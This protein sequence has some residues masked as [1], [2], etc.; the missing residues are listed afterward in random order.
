M[1][2]TGRGISI[3]GYSC[4]R[5]VLSLGYLVFAEVN[6]CEGDI[7][8]ILT[9]GLPARFRRRAT[10]RKGARRTPD[11]IHRHGGIEIHGAVA[12][13]RDGAV[14]VAVLPLRP[15]RVGE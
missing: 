14:V 15:V 8:L 3:T 13:H 5:F 12:H 1:P 4:H 7:M 11:H 6:P 9:I 10:H 2:V